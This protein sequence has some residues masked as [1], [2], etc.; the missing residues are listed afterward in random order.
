[1]RPKAAD[2]LFVGRSDCFVHARD[3]RLKELRR[4]K[5][6]SHLLQLRLMIAENV[7][8]C[9]QED[10]RPFLGATAGKVD[11]EGADHADEEVE[12]PSN[13]QDK[14]NGRIWAIV[15]LLL[16]LADGIVYLGICTFPSRISA[17]SAC[18]PN[19]PNEPRA[20]MSQRASAPFGC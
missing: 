4:F 6:Q 12:L 17:A 11:P 2:L 16:G 5:A 14:V 3:E 18:P 9:L 19:A 13:V 8:E 1:M 20:T 10:P 15:V 7:G